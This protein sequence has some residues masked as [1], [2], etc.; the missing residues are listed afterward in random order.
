M[1]VAWSLRAATKRDVRV[2]VIGDQGTGKSNFV[3]TGKFPENDVAHVLPPARLP[4]DYFPARVP[5]T[6]TADAVV[7]TYACDRPNTLEW[8]GSPHSGFP[9]SAATF[10]FAGRVRLDRGRH[11]WLVLWANHFVLFAVAIFL[12]QLKVPV[13]LAGCKVDLKLKGQAAACRP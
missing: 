4:V 11:G 9:S 1:E 10:S 13:I 8:S 7:L 2:A 6:I 12:S 5:V 3:T